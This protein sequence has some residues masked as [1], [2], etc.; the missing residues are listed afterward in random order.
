M[1]SLKIIDLV[2]LV[3]GAGLL[4]G[5]IRFVGVQ[6]IGQSFQKMGWTLI[7]LVLSYGLWQMAYAYAWTLTFVSKSLALPF[8]KIF[9][10]Y[11]AGDAVNYCVPSGN[12][13]GEPVKPYLMRAH[14]SMNDGWASVI[15]N[16]LSETISM[17]V[18]LTVGVVVALVR[19]PMPL[20]LR[21][22][23]WVVY[24]GTIAAI[25]LFFWRQKKGL[26]GP[27]LSLF[28]KIPFLSGFAQ[29]QS[30]SAADIDR[31]ISDY[32]LFHSRRFVAS[33]AFNFLGWCGGA[34]ELLW[35]LRR[36]GCPAFFTVALAIEALSLLVN[37]LFFFL[38]GRVGGGEGGKTVIFSMLG[39][40]A[41]TGLSFGMIRRV[42]EL[43]WVGV[44]LTCLFVWRTVPQGSA[45]ER[46]R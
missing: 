23:I 3:A 40:G 36:L 17:A 41:G 29:K 21:V 26:L 16:K 31:R 27:L 8:W 25:S 43:F 39:L 20:S 15:I 46:T 14:V 38:P 42:R 11:L 4:A 33:I 7:P 28:S 18:F 35:I 12:L 13:A 5:L 2:L 44:G 30:S 9:T 24:G 19:F 45:V 34:V 37:N 22:G 32:Y 6:T 1:K 10:I